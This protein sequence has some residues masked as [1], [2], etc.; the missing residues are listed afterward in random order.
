MAGRIF[1]YQ[2]YY[3]TAPAEF[4]PGDIIEAR[5]VLV[6]GYSGDYAVYVAPDASWDAERI[7]REGD[8]VVGRCPDA[9]IQGRRTLAGIE[10]MGDGWMGERDEM[11]GSGLFPSATVG[12][13]PRQ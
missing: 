2:T 1:D 11:V 8:K 6:V 7:V 4:Q 12:R 9:L 3:N 13:Y 10:T 5:V